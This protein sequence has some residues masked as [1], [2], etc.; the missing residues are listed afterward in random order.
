[1]KFTGGLFLLCIGFNTPN[2]AQ[3]IYDARQSVLIQALVQENP[4]QIKL[5]W[6][7]DTANGG[8]TIWRKSALDHAW[9]DS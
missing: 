2:F 5:S 8:Y 4:A 3:H 1:M 7:L 6:V 9:T